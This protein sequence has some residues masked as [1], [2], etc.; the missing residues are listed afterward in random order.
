M[1]AGE[2]PPPAIGQAVSDFH[3]PPAL[4]VVKSVPPT[5][6]DTWHRPLESR[7]RS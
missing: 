6:H 3:A 7:I 2:L 4:T 5:E 1:E